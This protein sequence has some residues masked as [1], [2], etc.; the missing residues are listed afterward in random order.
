MHSSAYKHDMCDMT[1]VTFVKYVCDRC[2]YILTY[3][4]M[5]IYRTYIHTYVY[6]NIYIIYIH[7]HVYMYIYMIHT[8][9]YIPHVYIYKIYPIHKIYP[10]V[11][12][13]DA[14]VCVHVS[15]A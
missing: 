14:L 11:R 8:P 13:R 5:Y 9:I 2:C 15:Y 3:V 4:Y 12:V 6:M 7:T 10:Y 1:R